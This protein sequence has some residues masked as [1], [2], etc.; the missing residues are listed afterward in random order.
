MNISEEKETQH[1]LGFLNLKDFFKSIFGEPRKYY[2]NNILLTALSINFIM[3]TFIEQ[4]V[5]TP[6]WTLLLFWG[7]LTLDFFCA[8]SVA[9]LNQK[10]ALEKT[11]P[12]AKAVGLRGFSTEKATKFIVTLI[13]VTMVLMFLHLIDIAA[14]DMGMDKSISVY[15]DKFSVV[16]YWVWLLFNFVSAIKHMTILGIV[17]EQIANFFIKY[18]DV[19]K[20]ILTK[21]NDNN[22]VA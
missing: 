10:K 1:F 15:M 22:G 16:V 20:N 4:W 18:V 19:Q 14:V 9:M 6:A 7:V 8:V 5:W 21:K 12:P 13:V 11:L 2:L 3:T 17:P